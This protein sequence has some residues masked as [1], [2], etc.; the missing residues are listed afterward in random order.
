MPSPAIVVVAF[1][2]PLSL[3][4]LLTSLQQASYPS[5]DIP[6]IIS[7]DKSEVD[8]VYKIA[9]DFDWP[10]GQKE[11]VKYEE[12]LGLR[13]H[14][15][16]CGDFAE[17]YEQ[18]IVLEDDLFASPYFYQFAQEGI[19]YYKNDESIAGISLYSYQLTE[20]SLTSFHP[21]DDGYDV[22]FMQYPSSWGQCWTRDQWRRF[23]EWDR[24]NTLKEDALPCYMNAW[25]NNSWKKQ[26][27]YY[28][29]KTNQYFV[30]PKVSFTTNFGDKGTNNPYDLDIY[31]VPLQLSKP[32]LSFIDMDKSLSK[33]DI[34]FELEVDSVKEIIPELKA[35]D[36][37]I[38]LF[39]TKD[40]KE[41]DKE[42]VLTSKNA[43]NYVKCYG[44]R[45]HPMLLNI[46]YNI[47]GSK[48]FLCNRTDV[49]NDIKKGSFGTQTFLH[50]YIHH[51]KRS[52]VPF[53]DLIFSQIRFKFF[54]YLHFMKKTLGNS[55]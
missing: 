37:E 44:D 2:R 7:I 17:E 26:F 24:N 48:V 35:Y 19:E 45:M 40:L 43:R 1:N 29:K 21:L 6:L 33:Y 54:N 53:L 30:Y 27:A 34:H 20:S 50:K 38:D 41:I 11:I 13:Q 51:N 22:Y 49:L 4:R 5:D 28:L 55:H 36:L 42:Y 3:Q 15:L 12:R 8:E 18:I 46:I 16:K 9:N 47:Y 25:K 52:K 39:G 14:V 32:A 31:Q 10:H 23:R